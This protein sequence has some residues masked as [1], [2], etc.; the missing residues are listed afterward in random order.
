MSTPA[1]FL[2]RP[3]LSIEIRAVAKAAEPIVVVHFGP[4]TWSPHLHDFSTFDP[5]KEEAM[6]RYWLLFGL[7]IPF[8]FLATVRGFGQV[9]VGI[10]IGAPAPAYHCWYYPAWGVYY[11]YDAHAYFY[12]N[13]TNWVRVHHLP[14]RFH[15]L[16]HHVIVQS[17]RGRPWAHYDEHR[18][19]YPAEHFRH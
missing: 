13:G 11:D 10:G 5:L 19:R 16:G 9:S 6:K 12:Q 14:P 18:A 8:C 2:K 7:F 17:E 4:E 3:G 1:C 15:H